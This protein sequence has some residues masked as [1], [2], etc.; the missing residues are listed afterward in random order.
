[1]KR[2]VG[3]GSGS[4]RGA[5]KYLAVTTSSPVLVYEFAKKALTW[6][7]DVYTVVALVL[8]IFRMVRSSTSFAPL[9]RI[10]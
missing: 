3:M 5:W 6:P 8:F 1:M 9:Q 2:E 7:T 4:G 10:Q